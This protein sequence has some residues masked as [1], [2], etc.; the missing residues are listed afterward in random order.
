MVESL[1]GFV[2]FFRTKDQ[3]LVYFC[4]SV[5]YNVKFNFIWRVAIVAVDANDFHLVFID[6]TAS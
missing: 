6:K 2:S 4:S 1:T 5:V 3:A